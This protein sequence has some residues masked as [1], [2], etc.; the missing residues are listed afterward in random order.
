MNYEYYKKLFN[1]S[2]FPVTDPNHLVNL[3]STGEFSVKSITGSGVNAKTVN[4]Y[5]P[6]T[7]GLTNM[8]NGFT[9]GSRF[10]ALSSHSNYF[11]PEIFD[12]TSYSGVQKAII[13]Y[14][15]QKTENP[16]VIRLYNEMTEEDA[17]TIEATYETVD[18]VVDWGDGGPIERGHLQ[19]GQTISHTYTFNQ[20]LEDFDYKYLKLLSSNE[21]IKL[22]FN[23]EGKINQID[24]P[25]Y[26]NNFIYQQLNCANKGMYG[27]EG[28]QAILNVN[29]GFK[30]DSDVY[31]IDFGD[32]AWRRRG[33]QPVNINGGL[34]DFLNLNNYKNTLM[35]LDLYCR[36]LSF[37]WAD[38]TFKNQV[39]INCYPDELTIKTTADYFARQDWTT[40][41][42][43]PIF[44]VLKGGAQ[45]KWYNYLVENYSDK[46]DSIIKEA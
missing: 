5:L 17:L 34:T 43:K 27:Y 42:K 37:D 26:V 18:Y 35:K 41:T 46:F 24:S 29:S 9:G 22:S 39:R 1:G 13:N 11:I 32:F 36:N 23:G 20:E 31:T 33:R 30:Y 14:F 10:D 12:C 7:I 25:T 2:F 3:E 21:A 28:S 16:Y 4:H 6:S 44:T 40:A 19:A 38:L 8:L 45:D 15:K